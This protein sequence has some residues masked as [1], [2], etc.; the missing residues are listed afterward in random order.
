MATSEPRV[1]GKSL[2]RMD[3][4]GKVTGTAVYAADF[5]LPGMLVGKVFRSTEPH[6]RIVRLDTARARA[7]PV[8]RAVM[9]A[10]D[11][12]DVRYGGALKDETVFARGRVRYVG[13]PVAA[14]AATTREAA[15]APCPRA[16]CARAAPCC[17]TPCR[18]ACRAA[19]NPR[20]RRRCP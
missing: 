1:V 3:G 7:L 15:P 19:R 16:R 6:A 10:A 17:G 5:A 2:P 18:R 4:A 13:Q 14:V 20:R 9:T 12:P 8:V 11:V